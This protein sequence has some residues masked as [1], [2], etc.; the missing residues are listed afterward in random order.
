MNHISNCMF[1]YVNFS[2]IIQLHDLQNDYCDEDWLDLETDIDTSY[3]NDFQDDYYL[4]GW[5]GED[6]KSDY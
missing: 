2:F 3:D 5:L 6:S 4:E 1:Q